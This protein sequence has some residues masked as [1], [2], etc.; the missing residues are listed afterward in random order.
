MVATNYLSEIQ[1]S[2]T[3]SVTISLQDINDQTPAFDEEH[4][5]ATIPERTP[6]GTVVLTVTASD[7]DM[8]MVKYPASLNNSP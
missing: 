1:R 7:N 6:P 4:Y 2:G 5:T 8:R 3:A